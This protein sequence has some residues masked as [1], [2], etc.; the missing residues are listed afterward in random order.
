MSKFELSSKW[1]DD[2]L[3][4]LETYSSPNATMTMQEVIEESFKKIKEEEAEKLLKIKK[5]RRAETKK[6][7]N[8][9]LAHEQQHSQSDP[10]DEPQR[11][12]ELCHEKNR[13]RR[14]GNSQTV[15]QC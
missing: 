13:P 1:S 6:K 3:K 14:K 4:S 9:K 11:W 5:P 12:C 8:E 10:N 7:K 2:L 15:K